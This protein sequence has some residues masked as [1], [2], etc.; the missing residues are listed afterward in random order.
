MAITDP[1]LNLQYGWSLGE[2]GWNIGMD[3][4]LAKLGAIVGL[5]VAS[6]AV[7][8]PPATAAEGDRYIIPTGATGVWDGK[9]GQIA[10][11]TQANWAYYTPKTGWLAW[12]EAET[13]L[14]V[15][16]AGAWAAAAT[17]SGGGSTAPSTDAV[18][19]YINAR[20]QISPNG[21][22]EVGR[23]FILP[24]NSE[25][26]WAGHDYEIATLTASGWTYVVPGA[27]QLAYIENENRLTVF[28]GTNWNASVN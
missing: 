4:N 20:D 26:P 23:R 2:N 16:S 27:G 19:A 15:Y 7:T 9:T 22:E 13:A 14:L 18:A 25:G 12:V 1:N 6:R 11:Y 5:S 8:D 10:V 17:S 21:S 24:P 3:A 28:N